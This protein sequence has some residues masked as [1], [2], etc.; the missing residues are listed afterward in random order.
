MDKIKAAISEEDFEHIKKE[1]LNT[2]KDE[3]DYIYSCSYSSL[4]EATNKIYSMLTEILV[5]EVGQAINYDIQVINQEKGE[6]KKKMSQIDYDTIR[7]NAIKSSRDQLIPESRASTEDLLNAAQKERRKDATNDANMDKLRDET[8]TRIQALLQRNKLPTVITGTRKSP[9]ETSIFE[10]ELQALSQDTRD[11]LTKLEQIQVT[12]T[13]LNEEENQIREKINQFTAASQQEHGGSLEERLVTLDEKYKELASLELELMDISRRKNIIAYEKSVKIASTETLSPETID[14]IRKELGDHKD[15][16]S[17]VYKA[18]QP[19]TR[20]INH[21]KHKLE[22]AE[23]LAEATH[24]KYAAC[25]KDKSMQKE[26]HKLEYA[27]KLARQ[28]LEEQKRNARNE[29]EDDQRRTPD[30]RSFQ[31]SLPLSKEIGSL[32]QKSKGSW[33][34]SRVKESL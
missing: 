10:N 24:D 17:A 23:K 29:E 15:D 3:K 22:T 28:K 25:L 5:Q 30:R 33:Q 2:L 20:D 14:S 8:A 18:A 12:I 11:K 27:I 1:I 4:T 9:E 6:L 26:L 16:L 32:E 31:E 7:A 21:L 34:A 13:K 19:L